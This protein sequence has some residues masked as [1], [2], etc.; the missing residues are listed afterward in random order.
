MIKH[1]LL[2]N[3]KKREEKPLRIKDQQPPSILKILL[4]SQLEAIGAMRTMN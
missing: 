3:T 4:M 1:Y 2:L